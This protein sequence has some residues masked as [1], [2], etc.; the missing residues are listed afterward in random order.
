M[1]LPQFQAKSRPPRVR[2]S[3]LTPAVLRLQDG[4]RIPGKLQVISVTGGLLLMSSTLAQGSQ[5][6]LMFLVG[7]AS[8]LGAAE[9]LNPVSDTLQ[10]FRFIA[11]DRTDQT[12]LSTA[13]E[14][15]VTQTRH[16][17]SRI[18]KFRA[19]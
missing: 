5:V 17:Q 2:L 7:K 18:E 10:P 3:E 13:I 6:K 15:S 19:W 4:R 16:D 12:K 9:M 1:A 14:S 11:L 8:V